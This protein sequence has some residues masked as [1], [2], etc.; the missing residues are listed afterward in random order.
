MVWFE[1]KGGVAA[2]KKLMDSVRLWTL[3]ENLG[4]DILNRLRNIEEAEKKD[5]PLQRIMAIV[6][7]GEEI[8]VRATSEHLVARMAKALKS[9]FNGELEL[10]FLRDE[11]F[12]RAHW[13]RNS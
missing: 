10:S 3:A 13:R 6:D 11:N 8:E 7:E 2:R 9:D 4:E 12:A 1:V 5:H